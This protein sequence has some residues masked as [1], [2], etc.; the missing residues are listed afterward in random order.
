MF[1]PRLPRNTPALLRFT[2][3]LRENLHAIAAMSPSP[4]PAPARAKTP[5]D[6]L[7]ADPGKRFTV[8]GLGSAFGST[9]PYAERGSRPIEA[10]REATM[11]SAP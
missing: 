4:D 2:L 10:M 3:R 8:P 5:D 6:G 7:V 11:S 9:F 1:S